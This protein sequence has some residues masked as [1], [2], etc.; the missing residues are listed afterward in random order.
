MLKVEPNVASVLYE[1]LLS[2]GTLMPANAFG[3]SRAVAPIRSPV[4][5]SAAQNI[6]RPAE[7][8]SQIRVFSDDSRDTHSPIINQGEFNSAHDPDNEPECDTLPDERDPA[9]AN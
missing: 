6:M 4:A 8:P 9:D 7:N 1:Q 3:V 2:S 5:A